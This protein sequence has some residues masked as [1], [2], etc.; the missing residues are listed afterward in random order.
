M[1]DWLGAMGWLVWGMERPATVVQGS[2]T[3]PVALGWV[4]AVSDCGEGPGLP[5]S[6]H[7]FVVFKI[8]QTHHHV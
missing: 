8:L 5:P 2:A 3:G 1:L 6:H 7:Q 4:T